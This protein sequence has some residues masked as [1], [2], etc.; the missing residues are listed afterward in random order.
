MEEKIK[1]LQNFINLVQLRILDENSTGEEKPYFKNKIDEIYNIVNTMP[2][3]YEQD[4]KGDDT[5]VYL[6]YFAKGMDWFI[7]EKDKEEEQLQAF[8]L[9]NM[10]LNYP[11]LGYIPIQNLIRFEVELDL[12][13]TPQSLKDV[14]KGLLE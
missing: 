10:D 4:G 12:K 2:K 14:K 7:T 6:H 11:E 9:V 13:W 1:Y 3:V 8:G 5:I